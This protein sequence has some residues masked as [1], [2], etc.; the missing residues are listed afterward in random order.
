MLEQLRETARGVQSTLREAAL[1]AEIEKLREAIEATEQ[2]LAMQKHRLELLA[3][4]LQ[5]EPGHLAKLAGTDAGATLVG[6]TPERAGP[7]GQTGL[8][9]GLC[10][11]P[12]AAVRVG[13]FACAADDPGSAAA[14]GS[15]AFAGR[16]CAPGPGSQGA[17]DR[18]DGR[19]E[20]PG[21]A[22][23]S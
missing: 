13:S 18:G 23:R 16:A 22:A 4:E 11:A 8:W 7:P 21:C 10:S 14:C 6:V 12:A 9:H 5:K 17:P 15:R 20:A 1:L 2:S 3:K 19:S